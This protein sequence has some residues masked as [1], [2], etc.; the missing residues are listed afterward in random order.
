MGKKSLLKSTSKKKDE[1]KKTTTVK[2][3]ARRSKAEPKTAGTAKTITAP[4]A[5]TA[6]KAKAAPKAKKAVK[7][8]TTTKIRPKK[9][10]RTKK[11]KVSITDLL[12]KKFERWE[13]EKVFKV[14]PDK[15]YLKNFVSPPFV[16]DASEEEVRRVKEL[17]F[18]KFDLK[19]EEEIKEVVKPIKTKT[20]PVSAEPPTYDLP[21]E[22][23]EP[24]PFQRT[25]IYLIVVFV[26]LI[27]LI[28][29]ASFSNKG[30][31]F[32]TATEG[33]VE[34]WQ[35]TFDP[36]GKE[37]I[38]SL[39]GGQPP[40]DIRN[41]YSKSEVFPLVCNYYID[42]TDSM[43][44]V[45][46][47]LDFEGIKAYLNTAK[48]YATT[49]KLRSTINAR[50]STIDLM[51][52]MYRADVAINKGTKADLEAAL[53]Y[54]FEAAALDLDEGQVDLLEKKIKSINDLLTALEVK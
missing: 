53:G 10:V 32:I 49:D 39:P 45:P 52:L 15:E 13:P 23:K 51:M 48:F 35:G 9:A 8:K 21:P 16:S 33:A 34:V 29:G 5:K 28:I 43:L 26:L 40:E 50:L 12:S 4:K 3:A 27:A 22:K 47:L 6:S 1:E 19:A 17:L 36:M 41:V 25:I 18:K 42:K 14:S 2:K 30:K 37:L 46:G 54:L 24:Y 7:P 44:N 20:E 38:I 11:T 31:Y